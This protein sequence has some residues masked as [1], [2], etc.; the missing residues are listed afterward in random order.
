ML[1]KL[2]KKIE[3]YLEKSDMQDYD[4]YPPATEILEKPPSPAGRL[5]VWVIVSC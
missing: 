5:L 3:K 1:K 4:F 2:Q